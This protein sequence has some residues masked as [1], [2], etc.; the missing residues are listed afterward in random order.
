MPG[1]CNTQPLRTRG[2][3][4]NRRMGSPS[5]AAAASA[6]A[7]PA[8]TSPATAAPATTSPA[9]AALAAAAT[10]PTHWAICGNSPGGK[11]ME[12]AILFYAF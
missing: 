10:A 7:A 12:N 3:P 2:R 6:I 5:A 11:Q 8:A 4:P 1:S 9:A